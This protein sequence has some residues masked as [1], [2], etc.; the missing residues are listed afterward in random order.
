MFNLI[1]KYNLII[2]RENLKLESYFLNDIIIIYRI[3]Y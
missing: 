3:I 1:F 2:T